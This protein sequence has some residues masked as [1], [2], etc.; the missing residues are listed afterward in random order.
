MDELSRQQF[1]ARIKYFDNNKISLIHI[2]DKNRG[3]GYVIGLDIRFT[4]PGMIMLVLARRSNETIQI[5]DDITVTLL[6]IKDC[7]VRIG[8]ES[9]GGVM[10]FL[11]GAVGGGAG[12]T[13]P[14]VACC[15]GFLDRRIA[16]KPSKPQPNNHI[17][18]GTGTSALAD[19]DKNNKLVNPSDL[20]SNESGDMAVLRHIF[21]I[22]LISSEWPCGSLM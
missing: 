6:E 17:I 9:P 16:I 20:H 2:K 4:L 11:A 15:A 21:R 7:Q 1:R 12:L 14:R 22:F 8:I 3:S 10:I 18:A 5:G 13:C 19:M